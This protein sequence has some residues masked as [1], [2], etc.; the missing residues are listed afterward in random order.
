MG[1]AVAVFDEWR[2]NHLGGEVWGSEGSHGQAG[3]LDAVV[4][5]RALLSRIL[6]LADWRKK[7]CSVP[8]EECPLRQNC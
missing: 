5:S 8:Q 2:K 7:M 1:A 6:N 3:S 4:G